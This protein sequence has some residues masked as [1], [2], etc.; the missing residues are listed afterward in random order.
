[1]GSE[2]LPAILRDVTN[3]R[4]RH[5]RHDFVHKTGR[6][7]RADAARWGTIR[8]RRKGPDRTVRRRDPGC[9]QGWGLPLFVEDLHG[10]GDAPLE[11][12]LEKEACVD[13]SLCDVQGSPFVLVPLR[14][15]RR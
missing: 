2:I 15:S 12:S 7:A 4:R 1:M 9:E 10:F 8:N 3:G 11:V 13:E 14:N 5:D 6:N